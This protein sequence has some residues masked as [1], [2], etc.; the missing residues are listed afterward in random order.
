MHALECII[1]INRKTIPY[2]NPVLIGNPKYQQSIS[3]VQ[4]PTAPA[5]PPRKRQA[6][7]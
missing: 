3:E 5:K 6:K 1:P 2:P 4:I 7:R